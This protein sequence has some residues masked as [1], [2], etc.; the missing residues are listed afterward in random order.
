MHAPFTLFLSLPRFAS[1]HRSFAVNRRAV[2]SSQIFLSLSRVHPNFP[3][4][5][6]NILATRKNRTRNKIISTPFVLWF[7]SRRKL[8]Q[9]F[10]ELI[11]RTRRS[12]TNFICSPS[13]REKSRIDQGRSNAR[14]EIKL[15]RGEGWKKRSVNRIVAGRR[16]LWKFA[17]LPSSVNRPGATMFYRRRGG[18][19]SRR[20]AS[21]VTFVARPRTR[22][23]FVSRHVCSASIFYI[24][25]GSELYLFARKNL[26]T[27]LSK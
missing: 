19:V 7:S 13:T 25:L 5:P 20:V 15:I 3:F 8:E 27:D 9:R 1:L 17:C 16:G 6:L 10:I 22:V 2:K 4:R 18:G 26:A 14:R 11:Q 23:L 12:S 24:P 21:V